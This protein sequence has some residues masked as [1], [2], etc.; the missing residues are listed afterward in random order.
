MGQLVSSIF[1][2]FLDRF[3]D[4]GNFKDLM[5]IE[6]DGV[7]S[8]GMKPNISR[9][10]TDRSY[11]TTGK[12]NAIMQSNIG[13]FYDNVDDFFD[14]ILKPSIANNID[15]ASFFLEEF[16]KTVFKLPDISFLESFGA[17]TE[18]SKE[19]IKIANRQSPIKIDRQTVYN[20]M[21][22]YILKFDVTEDSIEKFIGNRTLPFMDEEGIVNQEEA[23][24]W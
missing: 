12:L 3:S 10:F 4:A 21:R 2:P 14:I 6:K 16:Y 17:E 1:N 18:M 23:K 5:R 7:K 20:L 22:T 8:L 9:E 11:H 19:L 13:H 15:L 24:K